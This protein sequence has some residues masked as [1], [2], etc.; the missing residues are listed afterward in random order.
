LKIGEDILNLRKDIL[1]L[2]DKIILLNPFN[3]ESQKDYMIY[4]EIILQDD[5]L[6]RSEEK[7]YNTLKTEKLS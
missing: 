6:M 2:W 1:G 4:I 7:K 5:A 3:N